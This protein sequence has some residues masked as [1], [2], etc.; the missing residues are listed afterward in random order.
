[1]IGFV[2]FAAFIVGPGLSLLLAL[3]AAFG[4]TMGL[5][6]NNLSLS[7]FIFVGLVTAPFYL[8]LLCIP[9]YLY[10]LFH[11]VMGR[12]VEVSRRR[13]W[14]KGSILGGFLI[15]LVGVFYGYWMILFTP[16]CLFSALTCWRLL[17]SFKLTVAAKRPT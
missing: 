9:G 16:V 13:R 6:Q 12:G 3:P 7:D 10:F 11:H 5:L 1:L 8:A 15:S 14:I 17:R 4:L 2:K